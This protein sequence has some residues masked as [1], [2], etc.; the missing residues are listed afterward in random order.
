MT[1]SIRSNLFSSSLS[2]RRLLR[3]SAASLVALIEQRV[4]YEFERLVLR[5]LRGRPGGHVPARLRALP[6]AHPHRL[7]AD[8]HQKVCFA[9]A[10]LFIVL[11]QFAS[12]HNQLRV[13]EG[14]NQC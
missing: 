4:E 5:L 13:F 8:H 9:S 10:E 7:Q 1:V 12:L 14:R 2:S 3:F 11:V 6:S